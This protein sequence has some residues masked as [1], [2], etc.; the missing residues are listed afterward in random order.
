VQVP[1][2]AAEVTQSMLVVTGG[3]PMIDENARVLDLGGRPIPG[4]YAT[5]ETVGN[6]F[7]PSYVGTGWAIASAIM[8]AR[9][10]GARAAALA[11]PAKR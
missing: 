5:G 2:Y 11:A 6:I 8:M 1:V 9:A 10:A 7:G 4:L 3:G